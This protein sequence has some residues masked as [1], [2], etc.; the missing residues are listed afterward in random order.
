MDRLGWQLL[1]ATIS[2]LK[3]SRREVVEMECGKFR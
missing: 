3:Q 2:E 1:I